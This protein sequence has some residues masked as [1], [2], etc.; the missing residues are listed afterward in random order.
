MMSRVGVGDWGCGGWGWDGFEGEGMGVWVG[1]RG[2]GCVGVWVGGYV[3][4][5]AWGGGVRLGVWVG[6]W[7]GGGGG[8]GAP[9]NAPHK[10]HWH[11]ALMLSVICVWTNGRVNSRDA[12]VLRHNRAHYDVTVMFIS[13]MT[14]CTHSTTFTLL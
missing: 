7:A 2:G 5:G 8:G 4:V 9:M 13:L 11:G 10:G 1:V 12:G 3:D 6:V 14:Q